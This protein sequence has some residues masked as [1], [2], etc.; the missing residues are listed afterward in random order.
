LCSEIKQIVPRYYDQALTIDQELTKKWAKWVT[1]DE[2]PYPMSDDHNLARVSQYF[3]VMKEESEVVKMSYLDFLNNRLL[4]LIDAKIAEYTNKLQQP[5]ISEDQKI[6]YENKKDL[7]S[8]TIPQYQDALST[9]PWT[10]TKLVKELDL[11]AFTDGEDPLRMLAR[12]P[13]PIYITTSYFCFIED[14]LRSEGK[15]PSTQYW[16]WFGKNPRLELLWVPNPKKPDEHAPSKPDDYVRDYNPTPMEPVV[17]HLFGIENF[18]NT[19]VLS[20]DDY[21]NFLMK[22]AESTTS[23][24]IVP[25]T[26]RTALSEHRLLLLGYHLPDW[27]FR[28][29]FRFISSFKNRAPGTS[30]SIAI[31]LM[32]N[33][34]DKKF[35]EKSLE[36]LRKYFKEYRFDTKWIKTEAF[37]RGLVDAFYGGK[38]SSGGN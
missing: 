31:Q 4:N 1:D 17:Y 3:Q 18:T 19:L 16:S 29:L 2:E 25:S 37:I 32:P 9:A 34:Q 21:M 26:L 38:R 5:G 20:E 22:A 35:E 27:D 14:A 11:P 24:D 23:N 8:E 15:T 6:A 30:Q 12:L 10:F 33:L 36:Y 13:L 28:A 7:Y